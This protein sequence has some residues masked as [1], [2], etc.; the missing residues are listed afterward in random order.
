MIQFKRSLPVFWKEKEYKHMKNI[1]TDKMYCD[2]A[3]LVGG[4]GRN[5]FQLKEKGFHVPRFY[6][7]GAVVYEQYLQFNHLFDEVK[8]LCEILTYE[9][10]QNYGERIEQIRQKMRRSHFP[11]DIEKEMVQATNEII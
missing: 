11:T 3:S 4:K 9:N 8:E 5:L 7:V 6:V 2:N 10:Y 1:Y